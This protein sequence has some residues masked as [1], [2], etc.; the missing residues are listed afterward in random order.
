MIARERGLSDIEI[1]A[2]LNCGTAAVLAFADKHRIS[3]DWL[4]CGDLG[5]LRKT[6]R[7]Y[8]QCG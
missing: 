2:A 7:A 4:V 6:V 5:G 3:L 1:A 8:R